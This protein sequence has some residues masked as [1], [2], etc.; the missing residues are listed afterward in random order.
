MNNSAKTSKKYKKKKHSPF[1]IVLI[2]ALAVMILVLNVIAFSYSWFTPKTVEGKGLAFD[3]T[4]AI[5]SE[6]CKFSTFIGKIVT[7]QDKIEDESRGSDEK[8]FSNYSIDEVKYEDKSLRQRQ[9]D[10]QDSFNG[11]VTVPA[12]HSETDAL[13][14]TISVPGRVYFKTEVQNE[15]TKYS[16]IVSM[17][18][19]TMKANLKVCVTSPS[20]S[21]RRVGSEDVK[22]YYIIRN[23]FVKVKEET[24][25]DGPGLLPI[26][27]F[28][29]NPTDSAITLQIEPVEVTEN[30]K[31]FTRVGLYLMYN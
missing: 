20:N 18:I 21:V 27:W 25:A 6:N 15:D 8:L 19:E 9:L 31:T 16:S 29:E 5:R 7:K 23:A 24:D 10:P 2:V 4:I 28:V 11:Y 3:D 17:Y 12:A 14:N 22:D 13:G 26:E 30:N 1:G